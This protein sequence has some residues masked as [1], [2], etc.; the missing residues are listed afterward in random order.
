MRQRVSAATRL[1]ITAQHGGMT[2]KPRSNRSVNLKGEM[3]SMVVLWVEGS[4]YNMKRGSPQLSAKA[5]TRS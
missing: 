5:I 4:C 1:T 3:S 2:R